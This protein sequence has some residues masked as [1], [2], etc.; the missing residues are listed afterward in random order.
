M[1]WWPGWDSI[2]SAGYWSHFWFW[3]GIVCLF[4]L[5]ASEIVS[6]VYGLRKDE[7]VAIAESNAVAQHKIDEAAVKKQSDTE[8]AQLR[9]QLAKAE[10]D[11]T[12][13]AERARE[14]DRLR[15][16]RHLSDSQKAKLSGFL[17]I[18]PKGTVLIKASV[19]APDARGY[20]D[21]I[22]EVFVKAGWNAPVDNA[23]FVGGDTSGT[24]I[25][26]RN[27]TIPAVAQT[28]Y[29][30]LREAEIPIRDGALGDENG[31][32]ADEVWLKIGLIK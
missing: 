32:A 1:T 21:E 6:H 19:N 16:P 26:V 10:K 15:Q 28:V 11:A 14:L 13:A 23:M 30:A 27:A 2:A 3:F 24:W 9:A 29:S 31:P 8:A 4:A 25:T 18:A 5:G 7:L 20:A 12:E 17:A 22:A